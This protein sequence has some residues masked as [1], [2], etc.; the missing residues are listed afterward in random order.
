MKLLALGV[1]VVIASFLAGASPAA[2]PPN[3]QKC[4]QFTTIS[5]LRTA[6]IVKNL[7]PPLTPEQEREVRSRLSQYNSV[8]GFPGLD[9]I[10]LTED[11]IVEIQR[12]INKQVQAMNAHPLGWPCK[13]FAHP[14]KVKTWL[15]KKLVANGYRPEMRVWIASSSQIQLRAIQDGVTQFGTVARSGGRQIAIRLT[16]VDWGRTYR[17]T[18][19]FDP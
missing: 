5:G 10:G 19:P 6:A 15:R 9:G 16:A 17:F 8:R 13:P 1:V 14:E 12:R 2:S 11:Q 4:L 7:E 18:L 3:L